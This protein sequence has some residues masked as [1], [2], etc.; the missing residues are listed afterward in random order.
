MELPIKAIHNIKLS[1]NE[2]W[3]GYQYDN[4]ITIFVKLFRKLESKF[5][6]I[7]NHVLKVILMLMCWKFSAK[8]QKKM[9]SVIMAD[10]NSNL[11]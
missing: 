8:P 2:N 6:N 4:R 10:N 11:S 9:L 5:G 3:N 1:P 7:Y